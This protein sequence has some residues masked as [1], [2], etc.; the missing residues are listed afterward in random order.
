LPGARRKARLAVS[1]FNND[2]DIAL[3]QN[4]TFQHLNFCNKLLQ[5]VCCRN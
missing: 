2:R 5:F 3:S 4:E 1:P